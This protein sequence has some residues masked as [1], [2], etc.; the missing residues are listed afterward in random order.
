MSQ[1]PHAEFA[2]RLHQ[3][4]D[5]A[6]FAPGRR[7]TGA[8]AESHGV[9]RETARK[10]LTGLSLPELERMIELA[11]RHHVSFEWLATGR[12][13][14]EP[15]GL[16]VRDA[17]LKYGDPEEARLLELVRTLS[18]KQRRALIDLLDTP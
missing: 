12:G 11:I 13:E 1:A 3:A 17:W 18:H 15:E 5:L 14:A 2:R 4:L 10:W 6:G 8:L 7:R 16:S 9:S